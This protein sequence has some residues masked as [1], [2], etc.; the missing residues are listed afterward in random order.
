MLT[1]DQVLKGCEYRENITLPFYEET[2]EIR[3]LSD[4]EFAE[5]RRKSGIIKIVNALNESKDGLP[6]DKLEE[7]DSTVSALHLAL[8]EIGI[9]DPTLRANASNLMG[10]SLQ[11]IGEAILR[12]TTASRNEIL[13]FSTAKMV[14]D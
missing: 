11:I 7:I 5:A 4:A 9:V 1:L 2:I 14:S 6:T 12:L 10:G 13:N 3:P 8:A